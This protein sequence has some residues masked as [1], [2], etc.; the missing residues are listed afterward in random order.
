MDQGGL[1]GIVKRW[2]MEVCTGFMWLMKD[3]EVGFANVKKASS[4]T[5]KERSDISG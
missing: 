3:A 5:E 4:I 1:Q 2:V